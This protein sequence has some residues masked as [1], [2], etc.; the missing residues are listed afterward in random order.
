MCE[1][2]GRVGA[3]TLYIEPGSTWENGYIRSFNGKFRDGLLDRE[4]FHTLLEVNV[5]T[6]RYT[7]LTTGSVRTVLR[8]TGRQ[9]LKPSYLPTLSPCLSDQHNGW[10]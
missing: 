6:E 1:R 2:L 9:R 8:A 10:Y 5:L 3:R 4:V 7:E